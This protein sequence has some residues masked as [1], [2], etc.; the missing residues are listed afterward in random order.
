L[1]PA[2]QMGQSAAGAR[3]PYMSQDPTFTNSPTDWK[4]FISC[5]A[6]HSHILM[7]WCAVFLFPA[8]V[9]LDYLVLDEWEIFFIVRLC[10]MLAIVLM[11]SLKD[12]FNLSNDFIAHFSCHVV[13]VILMWMLSMLKTADHFFIYSFNT[14]VGYITSAIFLI[15]QPRHS[16]IVL[17]STL[18]SFVVFSFLYSTLPVKDIIS[19]GFLVLLAVMI[20]SQVYV[21]FRYK[22]MFRDF[23]R[24]IE[25]TNAYQELKSKSAEINQRNFEVLLQKEKLEE[26][27][28]LKDRIFMIISRDFRTPL[29]SLKGLIFLLNG[30]DLISPEEFRMVLKGLKHNVDQAHDL[31]ENVQL[32]SRTQVKDFSIVGQDVNIHDLVVECCDLLVNFSNEKELTILNFVE[33]HVSIRADEEIVRLVLR[34]LI[35]NAIVLTENRGRVIVR[36]SHDD[37]CVNVS[38]TDGGIGM[39]L[40][41]Q[42]K[43][44]THGFDTNEIREQNGTALGLMICKELIEKNNGQIWIESEAGKGNTFIF[45]MP[46]VEEHSEFATN[47]SPTSSR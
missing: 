20:I 19:H 8:F 12:R 10:G 14:S 3:Q 13:F 7:S 46:F 30:S 18:V 23:V 40:N 22:V 45:S 11:L 34:N 2:C 16:I 9:L 44:F 31:L 42:A 21:L 35:S 24:Q 25:L 36:S 32:W 15:W 39:D 6:R 38:V 17:T 1:K 41:Q 47:A 5:S 37:R 29:H 43:V 26:L 27:N 33:D 28:E 4:T